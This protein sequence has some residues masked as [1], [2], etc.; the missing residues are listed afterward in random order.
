MAANRDWSLLLTSLHPD[1]PGLPEPSGSTIGRRLAPTVLALWGGAL[2]AATVHAQSAAPSTATPKAAAASHDHGGMAQDGARQDGAAHDGMTHDEANGDGVRPG[3]SRSAPGTKV[4]FVD[5]KDGQHLPSKVTIHFGLKGMGVAP[6]GTD[7]PNT[8]H[9][10][11]LIDAELPPR[12]EPIPNDFNHLHFGAGQTEA[13]VELPPGD[14]SLLLLFGDKDHYSFEPP[15]AS[16]RIVVHVGD[17]ASLSEVDGEGAYKLKASAPNTSLYFEAPFDGAVVTPTVTVKFGLKGMGIAPAGMSKAYTGHHHLLVDT[18]VPPSDQP[19]P[20]DFNHYHF[21][22]G[23]TEAQVTLAPGMHTLQLILGD[24]NHYPHQ[25][26]VLSKPIKVFV[27]APV[28]IA[29]HFKRRRG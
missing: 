26:P 27:R 7:R 18:A 20:N 23:Q 8:G 13:E 9:H 3:A 11:L 17:E 12:D 15:V 14:H 16:Q 1:R 6:A 21:G 29:Q 28:A 24:A 19:I 10:H 2:V 25:P 22:Q 5:V 4:Y